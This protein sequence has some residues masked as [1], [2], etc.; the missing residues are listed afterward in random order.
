MSRSSRPM[1]PKSTTAI[2]PS[3][4]T[5]MFPGWRSAWKKPSRNTWLK[6]A[7]AALRNRSSMRCPAARS[8]ALVVDADPGY[9]LQRQHGAAGAQP[10]DP[11]HAE[12]RVAGEILGELRGRGS[13]QAQVHLEPDHLGERLHHLDRL[14][15]S[16]RGLQPL[17]QTGEPQE[18]VEVA[19][20]RRGDARAQHLDGNLVP[21]RGPRE[22]DLG[23]RG[24]GYR[25][26]VKGCEQSRRAGGRTRPR[27]ARAPRRPGKAGGGPAGSLRS[28]VIS[29][30]RRSARVDRSW[31]SL[32]KLGPN[33]S[34]AAASR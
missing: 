5:N 18:E 14:E 7:A 34:N 1:M 29:S 12:I 19:G 22:M 6:K 30:P 8:A 9:P 26:L 13:L 25:R 27:S 21:V 17:T 11:R 16:Q 2:A 3:A 28:T 4:S 33:S 31:P 24:G 15:P 20:K 32:M 23:D 10:I